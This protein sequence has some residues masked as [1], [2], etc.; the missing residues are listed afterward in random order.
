MA[1]NSDFFLKKTLG[2]GFFESLNK[3]ELWKPGTK[4]TIDHEEIKTALMIVP[5]VLMSFI[6]SN[7]SSMQLNETKEIWLNIGNTDITDAKLRVTKHE[8]DVYSGEIEQSNKKVV[9][10][11]YRSIPG[12]ALVIMSAFELYDTDKLLK[13]NKEKNDVNPNILDKV[14]NLIDERLALHDLINKVVDKKIEQRDAIQ[15]LFLAKLSESL[16]VKEDISEVTKIA[17]DSADY[18][19]YMRGM[20]NG[21]EVADSITNK[22]EPEFIPSS[23]KELPL[24]KFLDQHKI[25]SSKKEFSIQLSKNEHVSCSGC[26][27]DIFKNQVYSGCI[28][29]GNDREK[30]IFIKKSEDGIKVRFS[31]GWDPENIEMLLETLRRKRG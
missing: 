28:C 21:L 16:K 20:A 4:T 24:K 26:G 6:V 12:V 2:D 17:K 29:L 11:K 14:Q 13:E 15:Q 9:D 3:F 25:K 23:K 7:L 10:F 30:K 1:S 18:D 27:Q 5:R 19:E 22:K 31:A 8:R